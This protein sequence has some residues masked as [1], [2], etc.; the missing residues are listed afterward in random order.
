[1]KDKYALTTSREQ[2][3]EAG[4]QAAGVGVVAVSGAAAEHLPQD[5]RRLWGVSDPDKQIGDLI[6]SRVKLPVIKINNRF[7]PH[8]TLPLRPFTPKARTRVVG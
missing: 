1:M 4:W 2:V 6:S 8:L 5:R 7:P 3:R